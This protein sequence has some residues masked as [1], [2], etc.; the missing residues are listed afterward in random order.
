MLERARDTVPRRVQA[1]A[2]EKSGQGEIQTEAQTADL[3]V[4]V[5][6]KASEKIGGFFLLKRE[7]D[8]AV[9]FV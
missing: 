2:Q 6:K 4:S 9:E 3:F 5:K 8:T 7:T 1:R